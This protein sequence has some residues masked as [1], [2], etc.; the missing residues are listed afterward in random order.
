MTLFCVLPACAELSCARGLFFFGASD[1]LLHGFRR[2]SAASVARGSAP[3]GIGG[4]GQ[5]GQDE[6]QGYL[7]EAHF[8][9]EMN[10]GEL[11]SMV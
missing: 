11:E 4:R 9:V 5:C 10:S 3:L 6:E 7:F 8:Q 2:L 1:A